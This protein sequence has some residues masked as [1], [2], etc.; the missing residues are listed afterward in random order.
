MNLCVCRPKQSST[1]V[2]ICNDCDSAMSY[3]SLK[4]LLQRN[5]I[6]TKRLTVRESK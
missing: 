4:N 6:Y 3:D 5:L 1:V 2:L